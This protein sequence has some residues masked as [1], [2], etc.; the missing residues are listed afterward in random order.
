MK[1]RFIQS[2]IPIIIAVYVL[3][4]CAPLP[5]PGTA[6]TEEERASAKKTCIAR[7]TAAGAIG[8]AIIGGLLGGK[9]AKWESA[10][11]GAAAGGTLAFAIAWGHCI[12]LY[13]NLSS[14]PVADARQTAQKIGYKPSQGYVAKIDNFSLTP[15]AIAPGETIQ[16]KGQY[17]IM[18]PEGAREV[19]VTETRTLHYFDASGNTWKELGSIDNEITSALGTRR[20]EGNFDIPTDVPEGRYRVTLKI[21][22]EGKEDQASREL[23]VRKGHAFSPGVFDMYAVWLLAVK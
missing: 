12:S 8:G 21:S 9:N 5:P 10:A 11:I 13:S 2:V 22:S 17:Y 19:K 23:T 6:L 1:N 14:Y 7:Y 20:A 18:A 16:M 15:E 3:S 4:S